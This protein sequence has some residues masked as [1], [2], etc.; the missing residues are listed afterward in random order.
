MS[1]NGGPPKAWDDAVLG[2]S[3]DDFTELL[4]GDREEPGREPPRIVGEVAKL[5]QPVLADLT[6][7]KARWDTS[8]AI[9]TGF[10]SL[11]HVCRDEGGGKGLA[12]GWHVVFAA[13]SGAGKSI[14]GLNVAAH[15][16]Q[17]GHDVAYLSLEMSE[18]Q[19]ATRFAAI[20]THTPIR[21]LEPGRTFDMTRA[22]AADDAIQEFDGALYVVTGLSDVDDCAAAIEDLSRRGVALVIM[23]YIQLAW[24]RHAKNILERTTEA[25]HTIRKLAKRHGFVSLALSQLKMRGKEGASDRKPSMHDLYGGAPLENDADLVVLLDHS[26]YAVSGQRGDVDMVV[27]KNRHGPTAT[28]PVHIDFTTLRWT[29]RFEPSALDPEAT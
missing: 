1:G 3:D 28:V 9:A 16:V 25:S 24:T 18:A 11:D 27:D 6:M 4:G 8:D 13:K 22:L 21:A 12:K 14:F 17:A 2:L 26:S 19:L 29:E 10:S 5:C 15:A 7:A 20:A 23:D